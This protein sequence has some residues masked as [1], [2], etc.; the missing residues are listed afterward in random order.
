MKYHIAKSLSFYSEDFEVFRMHDK[1][2]DNEDEDDVI[3]KNMAYLCKPGLLFSVINLNC[4]L[5][6]LCKFN[7]SF[8]LTFCIF[9][10]FNCYKSV[11]IIFHYNYVELNSKSHIQ[12][13]KKVKVLYRLALTK[14][15]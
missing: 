2:E 10:T 6:S 11:S 7:L 13:I 5:Y 1:N 4:A 15:F 14:K 12:F 8:S 9:F 3:K